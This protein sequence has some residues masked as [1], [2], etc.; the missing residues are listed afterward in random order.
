M[1]SQQGSA[2]WQAQRVGTA[3]P[4]VEWISTQRI[5]SL[6]IVL[7]PT[8]TTHILLRV[9]SPYAFAIN[10]Q[11]LSPQGLIKKRMKAGLTDGVIF[12]AV[13]LLVA[14]SLLIGYLFRLKILIVHALMV[15]AY[16]LYLALV[17]GYAFVYL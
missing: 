12:G 8:A 4:F 13:S 6:P 14:F 5:P 17:A 1:Y 3:Y 9:S 7:P 11:L 10:P 2:A 16:T 15:F